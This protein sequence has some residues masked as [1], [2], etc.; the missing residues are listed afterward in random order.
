MKLSIVTINRN[1]ADGLRRTLAS[2]FGKQSRFD[3]WE[4]IVVDGASTDGSFAALGRYRGN[5]RLG[6]HVSEPDKGIYN[7]MNKGAAHACGDY[8]LFLNSGD[9]LLPEVLEKVFRSRAN[10]DIL[11]GDQIVRCGNNSEWLWKM[12]TESVSPPLFLV[13]SMPHQATFVSRAAHERMGGYD[14]S[15]KVAGDHDFFF[16]CS[17]DPSVTWKRI[18]FPVCLFD[19]SGI[20][21]ASDSLATTAGELE[22]VLSPVFGHFVA[23]RTAELWCRNKIA[24]D[25]SRRCLPASVASA[26]RNDAKLARL[27]RGTTRLAAFLWRFTIPRLF[28]SAGTGLGS[29]LVRT[30]RRPGTKPGGRGNPAVEG[31]P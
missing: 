3:D 26:A 24:L 27:L 2:T 15:F 22:R 4:Q 28:L 11:F 18:P 6:W 19:A 14:E 31:L 12:E 5:P 17:C 29:F 23:T 8:L 25:E 16:R 20:S 30:L 7:A 10:A 1:N 13:Q 9:E 21:N